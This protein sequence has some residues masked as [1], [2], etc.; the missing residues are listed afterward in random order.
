MS[1]KKFAKGIKKCGFKFI[2]Y[3]YFSK[4]IIKNN[5]AYFYPCKNSIIDICKGGKLILNADFE[6][7]AGKIKNSKAEAFLQIGN[8]AQMIINGN[9][10]I[11]FGSTVHVN[12]NAILEI[13]SMTSNVGINIQ[14]HKKI[15]IGKD[16]MFGRN[17]TVFDS[18]FHPTGTSE[19]NLKT[20]E[21]EVVI[22]NHVWIG[23]YAHIKSA[24]I[25]TGSIIGSCSYV[26]GNV[27]DATTVIT[28]EAKPYSYGVMWARGE[29]DIHVSQYYP[30]QEFDFSNLDSELVQN[31]SDDIA[32]YLHETITTIDF[33]NE[34]GLIEGH[35]LDSLSTMTV[36]AL[37]SEKYNIEIPY[38]EVNAYNFN[39]VK[40]MACMVLK[41]KSSTDLNKT[42]EN[43]KQSNVYLHSMELLDLDENDTNKPVVQRILE[44][45]K[46]TPDEPAIISDDKITTYKELAKYIQNIHNWLKENGILKGDCVAVQAF[47]TPYCIAT[48]YAV[49]L[50]EAILVPLEKSASKDRILE[51]ANDTKSKLIISKDII[52][53][54]IL[55]YNYDMIREI[56]N[57]DIS[58]SN[59]TYP[60]IDSP[61]EMVFTTG[62]TGKSKGVLM[63]HRHISWY[64]YATAKYVEM[65]KH[66]RFLLT[67]PL[68]HAGGIRRTH[69]SLA[70]GCTM[71]Y[72]D[73]INDLGKY[74]EYIEKYKITSLYMPPV[75][76][77]I[78]FTRTKDKLGE[79]KNQIDFVYSSSSPLPEGD[80]TK[81][82]Q[83]LPNTRLYNAYEA[84]ETPGVSAYNYNTTNPLKNCLGK[85]NFGVEIGILTANGDIIK[86]QNVQGQLCVKSKMNM[87]EYYLAP[88]LT[89]TVYKDGWFISSDLGHLDEDGNAYYEG[90]K[91][92][93]INIGGYKIAPTDVEE[94]ALKSNLI[95]ECICIEDKDQFGVSFLKLLVVVGENF[96]SK[97]LMSFLS[98]KLETYKLPRKI[99]TVD[100]IE[101]TFNGKI[102]RKAYR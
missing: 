27:D 101:K 51:I 84:S 85:A 24:K 95:N 4:N 60:N 53:S 78:L 96:E 7:N 31:L 22:G 92:D 64:A 12:P 49:H 15:S 88:E 91:G 59:I 68:N 40:N 9:S 1:L 67:T 29:N 100:H 98:S 79:Y 57:K 23:A 39:D 43:V 19:N 77:R 37:L 86:R 74:F 11:N 71:V 16:C 34:T 38:K 81:L 50:T 21:E 66:N 6:F 97:Q 82:A 87:K 73:G 2:K 30:N 32:D 8:N 99:E 93:V 55:S 36:V 69:L 90:R 48:Y 62:T 89:K 75:A 56:V 61:C 58:I 102:N 10:R 44:W 33:K 72:M 20:I 25:G 28:N 3:N 54:S 63:T 35:I 42:I 14:C 65:K 83:L 94:V 5:G 46:K 80:C 18:D 26:R 70:N 52:E 13:G 47:P 76:L 45:S 17:S 41:L